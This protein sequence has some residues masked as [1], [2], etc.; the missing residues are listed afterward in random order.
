M[1]YAIVDIETTGGHA[2]GNGITEVSIHLHDGE[3][4]FKRYETLINP[5]A[6]IPYYLPWRT[7]LVCLKRISRR[8]ARGEINFIT[9]V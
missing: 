6:N 3:K 1:E 7:W 9:F 5:D 4:V 2:A 8:G